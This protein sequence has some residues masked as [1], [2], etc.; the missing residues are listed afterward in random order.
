VY[1]GTRPKRHCL[2]HQGHPVGRREWRVKLQRGCAVEGGRRRDRKGGWGRG[3]EEGREEGK[4]SR[5]EER[6]GRGEGQGNE[7]SPV[8]FPCLT[9]LDLRHNKIADWDSVSAL[10]LL[11][12]LKV[13]SPGIL[14][15]NQW[16]STV[17]SAPIHPPQRHQRAPL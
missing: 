10:D 1:Q 14:L 4:K 8:L 3:R 2:V 9:D 7:G 6:K 16:Y 5:E 17:S 12:A 11:P 15:C 13:N